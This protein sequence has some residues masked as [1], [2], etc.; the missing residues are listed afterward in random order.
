V[1]DVLTDDSPTVVTKPRQGYHE[2]GDE[3]KFAHYVPK[4]QLTKAMIEGTP[5]RAL[6]GKMWVPTRDAE[7][8]PVCSECKEIW[9]SMK[10][11]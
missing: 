7:K 10:D 1:S 9:E 2:P 4:H 3:D 5:C 6:C 8:F 11:G